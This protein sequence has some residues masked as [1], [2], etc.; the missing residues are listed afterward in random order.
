MNNTAHRFFGLSH[1]AR[2]ILIIALALLC[3]G[4]LSASYVLTLGTFAKS[5][6][7]AL[8]QRLATRGYPVFLLYGETYEVRM[9]NFDTREKAEA[10]AEKLRAEEKIIAG[11]AEE[12]DLGQYEFT[13]DDS[14]EPGREV[15]ADTRKSYDD[16]RAQ[17]IVSLGLDLFGR[18]YKYGGTSVGKGID[19]SYFVQVIFRELGISLPRTSRDQSLCGTAVERADLQVG[20]LLFFQKTYRYKQKNQNRRRAIVRINHVGIYIGN[21]EFIHATI[22]VK[23]VTIS[24][25]DEPYFV[26]RYA[27]A[28]RV[29]S[30]K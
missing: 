10:M 15:N 23:R 1:R 5:D 28:L 17:K 22:N 16:P 4:S 8:H 6:A 2:G 7:E 12:G 11:V 25:I 9:G 3:A 26:K 18:P 20:D 21:H 19:C 27:G 24:N 30:D 13:L 29:L 14:N